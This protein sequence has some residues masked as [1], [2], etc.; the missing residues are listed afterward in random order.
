MV[1]TR[2]KKNELS[3]KID[4]AYPENDNFWDVVLSVYSA[5]FFE[6]WGEKIYEYDCRGYDKDRVLVKP[7]ECGRVTRLQYMRAL[8]VLSSIDQGVLGDA[9]D[10]IWKFVSMIPTEYVSVAQAEIL[11]M[12]IEWLLGKYNQQHIEDFY[13]I[14]P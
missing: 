6:I 14:A 11:T 9:W 4:S 3:N 7:E 5:L 8:F 13:R 10:N 2:I 1:F 12:L